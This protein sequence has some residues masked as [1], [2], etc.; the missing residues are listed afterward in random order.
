HHETR[1]VINP[2]EFLPIAEALKVADA[3]DDAV[4]EDAVGHFERWLDEGAA[5]RKMS[6]NLRAARLLDP[7]FVTW[8]LYRR[9]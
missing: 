2:G 3:I 6:V 8:L 5:P 1:G 7:R 4:I 9:A